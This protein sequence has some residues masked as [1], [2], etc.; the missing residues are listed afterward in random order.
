MVKAKL[1]R[2]KSHREAYTYTSQKEKK[3][4]ITYVYIKKK[5]REEPNQYTNL[6]MIINSKY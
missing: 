4:K 5:E 3:E 6:P 2:Q 1:Y